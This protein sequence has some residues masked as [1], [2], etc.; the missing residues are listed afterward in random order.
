[1]NT[2]EFLNKFFNDKSFDDLLKMIG[3]SE[4]KPE[5]VRTIVKATEKMVESYANNISYTQLRNLLH[6]VKNKDFEG[7][8][9]SNF[10][11]VIP[12][13]A[14]MEARPTVKKEGKKIFS[15]IRQLASSVKSK[16]DY[17][18]FIDI[19]DTIIAYHKL[20]GK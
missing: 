16:E 8:G 18:A 12:K 4:T 3:S 15:F 17:R 14:Y 9:F 19:M 13:I 5:N 10:Y 2:H 20:Y 1:M 6:E 11:K 7:D